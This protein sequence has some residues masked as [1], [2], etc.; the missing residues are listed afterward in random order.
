VRLRLSTLPAPSGDGPLP[1][2]L[3]RSIHLSGATTAAAPLAALSL[4]REAVA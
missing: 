3:P 4:P 1:R 2:S